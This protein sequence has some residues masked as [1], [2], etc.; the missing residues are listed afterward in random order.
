[1][2]LQFSHID[3]ER[4][5]PFSLMR[6]PEEM[7]IGILTIREKY[8]RLNIQEEINHLYL[9]GITNPKEIKKLDN[10]TDF[11]KLNDWAL[12]QDFTMLTRNRTSIPVS[13]TNIIINS[14]MI[15]VE[16]GATV[17]HCMLNATD[18]P[19]YIAKNALVMEGSMLRGPLAIGEGAVIKMGAKIYGAT[20][21]G[22]YCTAGGEIK[23][24]ILNAYSNKAHDGYLGDSLIGEWCNLGAGTSNSNIKNTAGNIKIRLN[25]IEINVG[26]KFGVIIG[27][28][29]RTAINTSLN[30]GTVAGICC[31]I[32]SEGLT[33][34]FIPDFSW[35]CDSSIQYELPKALQDIDNWKQL[36]GLAVTEKEMQMLTDLYKK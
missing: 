5:Y 25:D 11:V 32:F 15:F 36:K 6:E 20:T 17:E 35:G 29:S 7:R 14:S 26:N 27:D 8:A 24:S 31:N 30:T 9:Q 1:M 2:A 33:P 12:H 28:Y 16:E 13:T 23:N 21:I 22:P 10:I 18:G 3:K 4:F 34:T 19:I